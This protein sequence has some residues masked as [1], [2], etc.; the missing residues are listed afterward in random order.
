MANIVRRKRQDV[1]ARQATSK[2]PK[3]AD[4]ILADISSSMSESAMGGMSRYECLCAAL[5]PFVGRAN[6]IAFN[7]SIAEV[8]AD[9]LPRPFGWTAMHLAIKRAAELEPL[10]VLVISDG[11]PDS[12]SSALDEATKLAEQCIIDA[13]YIGPANEM[14]EQFMRDL[15]RIGRGR[16]SAFDLSKQTA[17]MLESKVSSMLSLPAPK[18][19]EL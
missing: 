6:V 10:H 5:A 9:N 14:N 11:H 19:V 18:T 8:P 15:A 2:T 3:N 13:L 17:A 4:L 16:Y 7:D 1:A 12:R